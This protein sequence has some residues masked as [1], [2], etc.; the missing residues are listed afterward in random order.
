MK[1]AVV[2]TIVPFLYGGAE[3]LADSLT[4][5][6]IEYGHQ[7][8]TI[9]YPFAYETKEAVLESALAVQLNELE[10]T[11]LVIALKFPAYYISHPNKKLWLLHHK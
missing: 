4:D 7:A 1:I 10:N 3:F 5:K 9:V 6:L 2:S 11:D 8:Q